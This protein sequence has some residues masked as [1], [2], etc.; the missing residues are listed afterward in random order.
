MSLRLPKLQDNNTK[1]PK[2]RFKDLSEGWKDIRNVSYYQGFS[3]ISEI[4]SLNLINGNYNDPLASYFKIM[5]TRK[6][7]TKIFLIYPI[8]R[9]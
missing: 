6:L 2:L 7:I 3:Y 5:R 9:Y 4:I 1:V 8:S